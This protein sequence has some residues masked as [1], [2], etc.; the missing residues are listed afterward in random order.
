MLFVREKRNGRK[1]CLNLYLCFI[2]VRYSAQS[3]ASPCGPHALA[4]VQNV[5]YILV[6][7]S[8]TIILNAY[9]KVTGCLHVQERQ[10]KNIRVYLRSS[11]D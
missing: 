7:F 10:N 6:R 5:P 2:R 9:I 11:V 4:C 3:C 1:K 8:R